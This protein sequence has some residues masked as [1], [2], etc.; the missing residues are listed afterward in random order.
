MIEPRQHPVV[1]P[2]QLGPAGIDAG[3]P[4]ALADPFAG[5][6]GELV[7]AIRT[8]RHPLHTGRDLQ[9]LRAL[10]RVERGQHRPGAIELVARPEVGARPHAVVG[11]AAQDRVRHLR[12]AVT[13]AHI[14]T[15]RIAPA[16]VAH[17]HHLARAGA[18]QHP[19]DLG[20]QEFAVLGGRGA[21]RLRH[22]VVVARQRVG[23][24]DRVQTV[25]RPAVAL[26][27][28]DRGEP[29]RGGVAVAMHE[30]DRR[31]GV[32]GLRGWPRRRTGAQ[33]HRQ[34][35]HAQAG[36]TPRWPNGRRPGYRPTR[37]RKP[38]QTRAQSVHADGS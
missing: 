19:V 25:A 21:R 4:A 36:T 8:Q 16:R 24:V 33:Q 11:R 7:V 20:S 1:G 5:G 38:Q 22:R 13:V 10:R 9:P 23:R 30:H 14:A 31:M 17:Q 37:R 12:R 26:E 6:L 18:R 2:A 3:R 28:P 15:N 27:A 29:Q 34:A 35:Q 32:G